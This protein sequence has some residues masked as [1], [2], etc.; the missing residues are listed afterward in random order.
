S[1]SLAGP[2]PSTDIDIFSFSASTGDLVFI[3]LDGDPLRNN[4]PLDA[5]LALLNSLGAVL[6]EVD[7]SSQTS[8]TSSGVGSLVANNPFSPAEGLVYRVTKPGT[9][10][11]RVVASSV[12]NV[13]SAAGDYLLS[14]SR[15]G[16]PGPTAV[17]FSDEQLAGQVKATR[18][19]DGVVLQWRTG[20]EVDN[21]GFNVYR[22]EGGRRV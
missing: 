8:N 6:V 22:E 4:T 1:G 17:K 10:Y 11:A 3:S 5:R 18:Y 12:N 13:P 19:T 2:A 20:M 16:G 14:I 21:L 15:N 7:D 9:Y